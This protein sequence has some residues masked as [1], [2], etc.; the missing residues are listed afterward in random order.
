MTDTSDKDENT[1]IN[2]GVMWALQGFYKHAQT[3]HELLRTIPVTPVTFSRG[4]LEVDAT[5]PE[6]FA[7]D[8]PVFGGLYTI[9]LDTILAMTAWTAMD[10]F[11]TLATINLK[12]DFFGDAQPGEVLRF[13]SQ[14]PSIIDQVAF[15][16]GLVTAADGRAIAQA[17][18]TFMVGTSRKASK[19]KGS[20]L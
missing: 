20:R 14:C 9:L 8:G 5:M 2:E 11:E 15:C 1:R 12:T 13:R 19:A 7:D 3:E 10:K 16:Q 4:L 18:G 6:V 17:D